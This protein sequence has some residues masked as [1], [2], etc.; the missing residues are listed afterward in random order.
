MSSVKKNTI[1]NFL[2]SFSNMLF[3]LLTMPYI[4][5]VLA[6]NDI[7]LLNKGSAFYALFVNIAS[8]GLAGY[9][10]REIARN[11]NDAEKLKSIFSSVLICHLLTA[12]V[13]VLAY[14]VYVFSF[15]SVS[16]ERLIHIEFI[17]LF[18]ITP[19][20]IEWFYTGREDFR[21]IA[22]RS[23]AV[24]TV[25]LILVFVLIHDA[26][27]FMLYAS[28]FIAA[29]GV[30]FLYNIFHAKKII[31]FSFKNLQ[32]RQTFLS[33]KFFYMQTLVAICY[34]NINQLILS[35]NEVQ[36]ALFVRA[37]AFT[38]LISALI[39]PITTAV[40][41][42]LEFVFS[43]DKIQYGKYICNCFDCV[44]SIL[45]PVILGMIALS[46]NITL[47]FGGEQFAAGSLVLAVCCISSFS[48]QIASFLN[49]IISTPAGYERNTFYSNSTVACI[50]IIAN[51][52][53]VWKYG[54][55]G[56][57]FALLI[58][59]TCGVMVH[60]SLVRKHRLYT[61]WISFKKSKYLFSALLM[62]CAVMLAKNFVGN[63]YLQCAACIP[64]GAVTYGLF[65]MIFTKIF[66]D[67]NPYI[68]SVAFKNMRKGKL[69]K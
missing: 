12:F 68:L 67:E 48:T 47:I 63:I 20:S 13:C 32:V 61:G 30:N 60:L 56:A 1:F 55:L 19:L 2:L 65:V 44:L 3:P 16:A 49:N 69:N 54:A 58:A 25:L 46:K 53:L 51:P 50:A 18:L 41:P 7:G 39:T 23:L 62:F 35:R 15:V 21:Y 11:K 36:L 45:F 14:C 5:R 29:Q 9:G 37:T 64:L 38:T 22:L 4:S 34:Q 52:F 17:L 6:I 26:S 8:F 57:A 27:D 66:R 59:E 24:K 40:K 42:R 33:S 31:H 28:I 43:K 10:A